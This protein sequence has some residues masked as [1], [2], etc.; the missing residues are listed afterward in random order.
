MAKR[1]GGFIGQ[2]G[3]N[4]PDAPTIGT[5]TDTTDGGTVSLT[6]TAPSDV[7]GSEIVN[8]VATATK[9]SDNTTVGAVGA[10]SPVTITGLSNN[11]AYTVK[12]LAVNAFGAS[13]YSAASNSVTPTVYVYPGTKT[14]AIFLMDSNPSS[15]T[16]RYTYSDNTT[17]ATTS[18]AFQTGSGSA[19][20]NSILGIWTKGSVTTTTNKYT[21]SS[22]TAAAATAMNGSVSGTSYGMSAGNSTFGIFA[23]GSTGNATSKYTYSSDAVA[24]TTNV[25]SGFI[26]QGMGNSS[27]G[28]FTFGAS[29]SPTNGR[30]KYTYSNDSVASATASSYSGAYYGAG[31]GTG[32]VGISAVG[33]FGSPTALTQK[34]TY[35]GDTNASATSLSANT[36]ATGAAGGDS[37]GIFTIANAS[38]IT[39]VYTYSGDTVAVGTSLDATVSPDITYGASNGTTGVNV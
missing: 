2:D 21:Y 4:A 18:L 35:S 13:V 7:G 36:Q 6:F 3:I 12:T 30:N 29:A 16:N 22:D 25:N 8:Y 19:S 14:M 10:T 39:N 34:Y 26:G 28:I 32:T 15:N 38:K 23:T 37:V 27:V 11:T 20:G 9:T 1:T 24:L 33:F 31:C 5:A 17:F